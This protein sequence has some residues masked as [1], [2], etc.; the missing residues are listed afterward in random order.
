MLE[1]GIPAGGGASGD[2]GG[3][4]GIWEGDDGG[5]AEDDDG[6][7]A[8]GRV[9]DLCGGEAEE[10]EHEDDNERLDLSED[11]FAAD[12]EDGDVLVPPPAP[13]AG[14][15]ERNQVLLSVEQFRDVLYDLV[16][17]AVSVQHHLSREALGDILRLQS[18]S[19]KYLSPYCQQKLAGHAV[20]LREKLFDAFP[21]GCVAFTGWR[22]NLDACDLCKQ[23]RYKTSTTT[24]RKQV[25]YWPIIPWLTAMLGDPTLA[26]DMTAGMAHAR[27]RAPQPR[28]SIDDWYDGSNFRK[29]VEQ[30]Y[31]QADTD[32]AFSIST[33]GFEAWRQQRFQGW[34]VVVTILNLA[35]DSRS[36]LVN[37][38]LLC[39]TPGPK[40]PADLE[41]YL[42]P[43]AEELN[44]LAIGVPGVTVA[45]RQGLHTLRG[46]LLHV[47]TDTPAG[48][49]IASAT[50]HNGHQPNRF[51][52]FSGVHF[53]S[54]AYYPP[55]NPRT[56]Q[57]L[58]AV[59]DRPAP[60]R[61][62]ASIAAQVNQVRGARRDGRPQ[63]HAKD[64]S[65]RIGCKGYSLFFSP[66][67]EQRVKYP[68]LKYLWDVGPSLLP[69]ECMHLLLLNVTPLL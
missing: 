46:F 65:K 9:L 18:H 56:I 67:P 64:L 10:D 49:K 29:A 20:D 24:P 66:R 54:H 58:F 16:F 7:W 11:D 48:D 44:A 5:E 27:Q 12:E 43:I 60:R 62:A 23:A 38:I 61:T 4:G 53:K 1:A 35:A 36:R 17:H 57:V 45:G 13:A 19:L 28:T 8:G 21:A 42:Q 22:S 68:A 6:P 47:F 15:N 41:E 39:V 31:F 69:Y 55:V 26:S 40:Q 63:S 25:T 3:S 59:D 37:Q 30:G 33:D 2:V 14:G 34:P 50:V 32:I 51:R 52:A